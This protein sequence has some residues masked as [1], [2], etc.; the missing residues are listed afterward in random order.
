MLTGLVV[1]SPRLW[2]L[3][4]QHTHAAG[5]QKGVG[6]GGG[7]GR[8]RG[9]GGHGQAGAETDNLETSDSET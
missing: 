9:E 5:S 8:G 2:Y 6:G 7:G 1:T 4:K 3:V